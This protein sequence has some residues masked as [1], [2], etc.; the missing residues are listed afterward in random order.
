MDAMSTGHPD[1]RSWRP[2]VAWRH[3]QRIA[4]CWDVNELR[5]LRHAVSL[6]Q[7]EFAAPGRRGLEISGW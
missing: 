4:S 3:R 2:E 5:Q 1:H 6:S 7:R